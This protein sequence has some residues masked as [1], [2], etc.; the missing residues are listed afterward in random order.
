MTTRRQY[1]CSLCDTPGHNIRSCSHPQIETTWNEALRSVDLRRAERLDDEDLQEVYRLFNNISLWLL[2]V[3]GARYANLQMGTNKETVIEHLCNRIRAEAIDF[4]QLRYDERRAYMT[5]IGIEYAGQE[6]DDDFSIYSEEDYLYDP[7]IHLF[8]VDPVPT[9]TNT[10]I[11]LLYLCM[12][13]AEELAVKVECA[14][15]YEDHALLNMD[16][17]DCE[18]M[19]CHGCLTTQLKTIK[20]CALCRHPIRTVQIRDVENYTQS[21]TN[22]YPPRTIMS[23]D[24]IDYMVD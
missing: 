6:D 16:T 23:M 4:V 17:V 7:D 19:F 9:N 21:H 14:I 3:L 13:S 18:H 5:R 15:C 20:S 2:W 12:E 10:N 24:V 22:M 1:R 11:N 8:Q